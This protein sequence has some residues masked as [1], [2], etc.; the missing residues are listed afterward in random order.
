MNSNDN[1]S[2]NNNNNND[3]DGSMMMIN[4]TIYGHFYS[5]VTSCFSF[6]TLTNIQT[7]QNPIHEKN[8]R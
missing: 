4:I 5:D 3:D 1:Y 6:C 7:K 8:K 2:N